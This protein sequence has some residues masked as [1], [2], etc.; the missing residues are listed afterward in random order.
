M[1]FEKQNIMQLNVIKFLME[2]E[3][4]MI[5]SHILLIIFMNYKIAYY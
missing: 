5:T 3:K 1:R 4:C 2:L